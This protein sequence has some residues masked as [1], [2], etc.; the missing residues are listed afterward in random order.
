MEWYW[1]LVIAAGVL[2]VLFLIYLYGSKSLKNVA[3][4]LVCNAE[5]MIGSGNGAEKYDLVLEHLSKLT[6]GIIS[7]PAMK[8]AIEWGV[9]RMKEMLL[10]DEESQKKHLEGEK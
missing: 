10:E 6:K 8:K 4:E 9:A 2:L 5:K 7:K 3:Y 1:W